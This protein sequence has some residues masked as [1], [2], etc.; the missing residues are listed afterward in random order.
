MEGGI[1]ALILGV[2]V[3]P[4]FITFAVDNPCQDL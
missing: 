4:D 1:V 2:R 3:N